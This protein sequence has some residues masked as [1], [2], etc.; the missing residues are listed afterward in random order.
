MST[1]KMFALAS[2]IM[3][4]GTV[5]LGVQTSL[6]E[7]AADECKTTPGS[8]APPGQHWYYRV[9]RSDQRHCW[10]LGAESTK[11][12]AQTSE[13]ESS[14]PA[15]TAR[16]DAS[17]TTPTMPPPME[18]VIQTPSVPA[19]SS[20]RPAAAADVARPAL[21]LPQAP[22]LTARGA[23]TTSKSSAPDTTDA[24]DEM[25]LVWPVLTE[26]ERAGLPDSARESAPWSVFLIAGGALL[27]AG[28]IF[29]LAWRARSHGRR[30]PPLRQPRP[31]QQ[32]RAHSAHMAAPSR[33]SRPQI[34]V[35]KAA[36]R[37]VSPAAEVNRSAAGAKSAGAHA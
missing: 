36:R 27:V 24:Q 10:Y 32:R 15:G 9:N 3:A 6:A 2:L 16:E 30:H 29:K 21:D 13:K 35:A 18:V 17:E 23:A 11:V 5:V 37:Q 28:G 4:L 20:E 8:S 1:A 34:R 22:D 19:A 12:R 31:R 25:P 33:S 26:A 14:S 7:P